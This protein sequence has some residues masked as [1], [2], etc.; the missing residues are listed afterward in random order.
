MFIY[1]ENLIRVEDSKEEI[2]LIPE[3]RYLRRINSQKLKINENTK[4]FTDLEDDFYYL[5]ESIQDSLQFFNLKRELEVIR[6]QNIETHPEIQTFLEH[7][8]SNFPEGFYTTISANKNFKDQGYLLF[9]DDSKLIIEASSIRGIYYGIQ[10]FI[11]LLNSN[12]D[13]LTINNL[14]IL[15]FP[16][17]QI[18]GISDDISRGQAATIE[19]LK[20]F[21]KNLSH[22]KINQYYLAYMQDMF[23]FDHYPDISI[24]RGAYSKEEIKEL[25]EFGKKYFI[26]IIPILNTLGHWDNILH[27]QDY[28]KYGEF[29][30]SNSL[31]LANEEIYTLLDKMIGELSEVFTSEFFHIGADES[32][33]VGKVNS[34]QYVE[35][36]GL[37]K[38]YLKHYKKVYDIAKKHGYK[39]VIIYHDV[40]HKF[41]DILENPSVAAEILGA[42]LGVVFSKKTEAA[43]DLIDKNKVKK[44]SHDL[45]KV[46]ADE[47]DKAIKVL[48]KLGY[49]TGDVNNG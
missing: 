25:V 21:I 14:R 3:P 17:L 32:F 15:D 24:N 45:E 16:A 1:L 31:N 13:K 37:G 48:S 35:E 12:R 34:R 38:A 36:V 28:W 8:I 2:Y 46:P 41:E 18:R 47:L 30:G 10:T 4:L 29:P 9:S 19:N 40:L 33:D 5:I 6:A 42:F 26:E 23:K 49:D 27:N 39:K 11:Q 20:K 7:N 22:F 43:L 44:R